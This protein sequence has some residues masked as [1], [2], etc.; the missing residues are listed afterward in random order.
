MHEIKSEK[1]LEQILSDAA[2]WL[3]VV[4]FWADWAPQCQQMNDVLLE[5]A[6]EP[7]YVNSK[8]V[9]VEAEAVPELSQKYSVVAVPTCILFKNKSEVARING[10]NVPE[11]TKKVAQHGAPSAAAVPSTQKQ[12][13][14]E[15]LNTK[16][17]RLITSAP[18]MLF[19]KGN[20]DEP[21]CGFSKQIIS[22]LNDQGVQYQTFDILSDEEVRQGLKSYSDWPTYPQLYA[23]GELLGGLD[24]VKE[25]VE[26]GDLKDAL[27]TQLTLDERLKKLIN[28][29]KCVVFMK[30]HPDQPRCGFSKTL[31]GIL[32]ETGVAYDHFDILSDE[33]VR[34]GLKTYSNWPT[35]P[36]VYVD[37]ELVGGLDIIK[38]LKET[39]ELEA[40]LKGS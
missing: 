23:D 4:H 29:A 37:G 3:V 8:F 10:A 27:P 9:K 20:K 17:K 5:L 30:G 33:E 7:L 40:A 22:I 24:I 12:E 26:S 38:E 1:E 16:L 39:N 34:Q 14:K 18:V 21:R 2:S 15:D 28:K 19:M 6:Q 35:Y 13:A 31:V 36:Q 11:L 25:M 32:A